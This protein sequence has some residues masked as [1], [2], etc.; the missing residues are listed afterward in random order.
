[1]EKVFQLLNEIIKVLSEKLTGNELLAE[2]VDMHS[3]LREVFY[4]VSQEGFDLRQQV[5]SLINLMKGDVIES[6]PIIPFG[7]HMILQAIDNWTEK[8]MIDKSRNFQQRVYDIL[9]KNIEQ[10]RNMEECPVR[11]YNELTSIQKLIKVTLDELT[12]R[13]DDYAN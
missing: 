13:H 2:C 6:K 9:E 10:L 7:D 4:V 3:G 5:I 8:D 11:V 12:T 1:M